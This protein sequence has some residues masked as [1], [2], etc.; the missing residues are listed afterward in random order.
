MI[1]AKKTHNRAKQRPHPAY[2]NAFS[3][4]VCITAPKIA[5][6]VARMMLGACCFAT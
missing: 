1:F 2:K 4:R 5:S 3:M 6:Y